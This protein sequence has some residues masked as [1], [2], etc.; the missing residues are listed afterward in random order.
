MPPVVSFVG[1][2]GAGKTTILEKVIAELKRRGYRVAV[3]KHVHHDFEIDYA[4]KDSWRFTQAGSDSVVIASAKKLALV[5][6]RTA[7]PP[8]DELV[9]MVEGR[10]DIVLTEGFRGSGKP[11]ILVVRGADAAQVSRGETDTLA[12]VSDQPVEASVPRFEFD[13]ATRLT[14]FLLARLRPSPPPA[15]A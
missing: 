15:R 2:S 14:D 5:E 4:G 11:Q 12:I 13:E 9:A 6:Q 1:N 10:A 7:Q 3:I 8:L